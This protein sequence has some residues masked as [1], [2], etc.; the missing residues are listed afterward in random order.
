MPDFDV[1][2]MTHGSNAI[3]NSYLC[4]IAPYA[5]ISIAD[6]TETHF[7]VLE[8]SQDNA[9]YGI[10]PPAL[11]EILSHALIL[12]SKNVSAYDGA[13]TNLKGTPWWTH[14][15]SIMAGAAKGSGAVRVD[16]NVHL[17]IFIPDPRPCWRSVHTI[18]RHDGEHRHC[19]SIERRLREH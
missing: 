9:L 4:R 8:D 10:S 12:A 15:L 3:D 6:K 16:E 14:M 7:E 18:L 13:L 2:P 19:P 17:T 1:A 11:P 5:E